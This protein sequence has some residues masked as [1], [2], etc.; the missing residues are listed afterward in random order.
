MMVAS[1][2]LLV[3]VAAVGAGL[4]GDINGDG[5]VTAA[6]VAVFL[7]QWRAAQQGQVWDSAADLNGDGHLTHEDARLMVEA[8]EEHGEQTGMLTNLF[9]L[10][11]STGEG[12]VTEGHMR[13]HIA[14][15]NA[16]HGTHFELWDHEYNS[17]GL[18]GPDGNLTGTNYA[19]PGDNTDPDGLHNLWTSNAPGW[20]WSRN[21][22]MQH[23]E[24]IAFKSCFPASAIDSDAMLQQYKDWYLDMRDF[25]DQHPEKLFVVMSPPPLHRLSTTMAQ[26]RRAR[27]FANWLKSSTYLSGHP[28][29]VCFDLFDMLAHPD[30]G[31][32]DA[33]MLRR[34]YERDPW[35]DSHPNTQANQ[36]VGA[37]LAQF[38]CQAA[39]NY[40]P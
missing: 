37:A 29:V 10:H 12:F 39:E 34:E 15:Y 21:Q 35:G 1:L 38:L 20:T 24:V 18:R 19:I 27:D 3:V 7:A 4:Q 23:H 6:D 31:S 36:V 28:N 11:H 26:A 2:V 30:D 25:F 40:S 13:Q 17:Q 32:V 16:A 22:I 9:F 8:Y 14:D 5:K 33:N